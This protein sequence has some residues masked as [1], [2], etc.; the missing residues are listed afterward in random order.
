MTTLSN[1]T[2][3]AVRSTADLGRLL[4]RGQDWIERLMAESEAMGVVERINGGWRLSEAGE[5]RFGTALRAM[6]LGRDA[7]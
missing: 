4:N 2:T 5:R 6:T 3:P 7:L 1:G